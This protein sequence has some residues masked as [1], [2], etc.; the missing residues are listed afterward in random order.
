MQTLARAVVRGARV[1]G[2]GCTVQRFMTTGP[3]ATKSYVNPGP[4]HITSVVRGSQQGGGAGL[5]GMGQYQLILAEL[6]A[7]GV[8][9]DK[10]AAENARLQSEFQ[11]RFFATL[12]GGTLL[13]FLLD[14]NGTKK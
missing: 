4:G 5:E 12:V 2:K 10:N 1:A 8:E 11:V 6:R 9:L 7:M 13:G 3:G 14:T